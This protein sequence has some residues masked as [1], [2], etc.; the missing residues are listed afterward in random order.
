VPVTCNVLVLAAHPIELVS[1][2]FLMAPHFYQANLTTPS[3]LL[4]IAPSLHRPLPLPSC[5]N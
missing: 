5:D 2:V 3:V 4:R 1:L